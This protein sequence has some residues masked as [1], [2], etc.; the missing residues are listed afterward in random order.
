MYVSIGYRKSIKAASNGNSI[1]QSLHEIAERY[2]ALL[3][4]VRK[5]REIL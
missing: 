2:F 3:A 4:G 5:R 1:L